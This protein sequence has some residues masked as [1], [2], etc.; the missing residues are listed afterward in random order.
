M[1]GRHLSDHDVRHYVSLRTNDKLS[2]AAAK[3]AISTA[4]AYRIEADPRLPSSNGPSGAAAGPTRWPASSPR[5]SSRCWSA[6][7]SCAR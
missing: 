2:V 1:P 3:A 7:R 4:S 6:R 5:R